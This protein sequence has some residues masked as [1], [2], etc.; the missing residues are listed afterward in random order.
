M[1]EKGDICCKILYKSLV[2]INDSLAKRIVVNGSSGKIAE[3]W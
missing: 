3:K 2:E 1:I